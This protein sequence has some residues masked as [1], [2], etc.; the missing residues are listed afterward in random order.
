MKSKWITGNRDPCP[1]NTPNSFR[2]ENH[3][4]FPLKQKMRFKNAVRNAV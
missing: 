1:L 4:T 3:G 2:L